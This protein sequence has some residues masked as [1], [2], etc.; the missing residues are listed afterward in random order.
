[1]DDIYL[2]RSNYAVILPY[3]F[4]AYGY[5]L[6]STYTYTDNAGIPLMEE[7]MPAS[8]RYEQLKT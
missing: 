4:T 1:V 8:L 5:V 2:E 7:F 3:F 6:F